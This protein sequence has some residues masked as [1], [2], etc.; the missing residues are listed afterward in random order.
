MESESGGEPGGSGLQNLKELLVKTR[1]KYRAI[2]QNDSRWPCPFCLHK[3]KT[4]VQCKIHINQ[5]HKIITEKDINDTL[6]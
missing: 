6:S 5:E 1:D 2:H 4:L 3:A